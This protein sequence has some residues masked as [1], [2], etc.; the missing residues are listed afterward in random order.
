MFPG[1][2]FKMGKETRNKKSVQAYRKEWIVYEISYIYFFLFEKCCKSPSPRG[3]RV[4]PWESL[5]LLCSIKM[6]L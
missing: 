1:E 2:R 3:K 6:G 5:F 4:P